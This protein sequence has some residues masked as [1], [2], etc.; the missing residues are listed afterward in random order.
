MTR[1]VPIHL[2]VAA[3]MTAML[4]GATPAA[5]QT[6]TQP[7]APRA[8][9]VRVG[10]PRV[11]TPPPSSVRP[12]PSV[13]ADRT[14][15]QTVVLPVSSGSP[16]P[17]SRSDTDAESRFVPGPS[18]LPLTTASSVEPASG[19]MTASREPIADPPPPA[20]ATGRCRNG[21]YV[22]GSDAESQCESHGGIAVTFPVRERARRIP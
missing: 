19:R 18:V 11:N 5:A 20:G 15:T 9:S 10:A 13:L 17:P 4:A 22:S 1:S 16:P 21:S 8:D 6:S 3:V 12:R 2:L 14:P 7:P